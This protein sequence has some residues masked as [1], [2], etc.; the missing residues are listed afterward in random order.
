MRS[1]ATKLGFVMAFFVLACRGSKD[2]LELVASAQSNNA[3]N[4]RKAIRKDPNSG[5]AYLQLALADEKRKDGA[6][7]MLYS[8]L[9][10][11][12]EYMR[13]NEEASVKLAVLNFAPYLAGPAKPEQL[14][15]NTTNMALALLDQQQRKS[16][17]YLRKAFRIQ[18]MDSNSNVAMTLTRLLAGPGDLRA[19]MV[20]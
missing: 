15:G 17:E 1:I 12:V 7:Q 4:F 2:Y 9:S 10:Q 19:T 11:A 8:A 3:V 13:G 20:C 5:E 18:P 16:I 6:P 14:S